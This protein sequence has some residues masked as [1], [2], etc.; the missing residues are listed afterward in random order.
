M[1]IS[2]YPDNY[3]TLFAIFETIY[4]INDLLKEDI[5]KN[6]EVL[7]VPKKTN[8]LKSGDKSNAIYFIISGT[9]RIYYLDKEGKESNTWF[10]FENDLLISVYSF[11]TGNSSFEYIETLDDCKLISLKRELLNYLYNKYMEFNFVGRKLTEYYYMRN[12]LQANELRM[13]SAKERYERLLE[14]NPALFQ[15][16]S[17][18]HIASYLGISRETLSRIRNR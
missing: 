18:S 1:K 6:S 8:L 11:Y 12:E 2:L 17:L 3:R 10:L 4:P 15:R 9:A 14:R 13:L 5:I 7:E 16:V